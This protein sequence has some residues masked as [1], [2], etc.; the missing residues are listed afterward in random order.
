MQPSASPTSR[1]SGPVEWLLSQGLC[2]PCNVR[3]YSL[4]HLGWQTH[5]DDLGAGLRLFWVERGNCHFRLEGSPCLSLDA[6][7]AVVLPRDQILRIEPAGARPMPWLM[8][9]E[10]QTTAWLQHQLLM[11]GC[12]PVELL[13]GPGLPEPLQMMR[14]VVQDQV[15]AEDSQEQQRWLMP[16][17]A[18]LV[19]RMLT[20][21]SGTTSACPLA[22]IAHDRRLGRAVTDTLLRDGPLPGIDVLAQRCHCARATFTNRFHDL[23]GDSYLSYLTAWRMHVAVLRFQRQRVTVAQE[24]ARYGYG[25]EA[26]FR[27]AF[28]RVI[29]TPPGSVRRAAAPEPA[30][31]AGRVPDP[32]PPAPV[33]QISQHPA[34]P[35]LPTLIASVIA[36]L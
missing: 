1:S 30:H 32:T 26:G 15:L 12:R 33:I 25:S 36:R 18:A 8:V 31:R 9:V 3:A 27:K 19:S 17:A 35:D 11:P 14:L 16:A 10:I 23:T 29:G 20:T 24:A 7:G 2:P 28:A 6:G 5:A 4:T 34:P 13:R 21:L 22:A